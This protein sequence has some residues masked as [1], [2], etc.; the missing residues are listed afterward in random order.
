MA[1]AS[2]TDPRNKLNSSEEDEKIA[3]KPRRQTKRTNNRAPN[4]ENLLSLMRESEK[5]RVEEK[6]K[7]EAKKQ[8]QHK[9]KWL[10]SMIW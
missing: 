3:D 6:K 1:M 9:K 4:A 10:Y 5:K 2:D 8:Q 7:K